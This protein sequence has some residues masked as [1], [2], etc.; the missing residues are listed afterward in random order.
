MLFSS[1]GDSVLGG[2]AAG[3]GW[4]AVCW[5]S[6]SVSSF[7]LFWFSVGSLSS[8]IVQE[9]LSSA[10]AATSATSLSCASLSS[11]WP[12]FS[13][14]SFKNKRRKRLMSHS[15]FSYLDY[16]VKSK[17]VFRHE[18]R[19]IFYLWTTQHKIQVKGWPACRRHTF[20]Y[21]YS[22]WHRWRPFTGIKTVKRVYVL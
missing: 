22:P 9:A 13:S 8:V 17:A 10:C 14:G 20:V 2:C 21:I 4:E 18:L 1:G 7:K 6:V 19:R 12:V 5:V 11:L 3:L 15:I 16:N